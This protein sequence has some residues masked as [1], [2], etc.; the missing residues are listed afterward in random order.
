M[1]CVGYDN[2][3]NKLEVGDICSFK[4]EGESHER[5]GI[6]MY[7]EDYFAFCFDMNEDQFPS[8]L[9]C[10]AELGTIK[11]IVNVWSTKTSDE[12]YKWYQDIIKNDNYKRKD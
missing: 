10:K 8:V 7:S 11:K 5:E 3:G 9:M 1:N 12:K 6:I 4:L 2:I